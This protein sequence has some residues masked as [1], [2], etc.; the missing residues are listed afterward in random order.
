VETRRTNQIV[1]DLSGSV[2]SQVIGPDHLPLLVWQLLDQLD[3]RIELKVAERC[4]EA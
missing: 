3:D 4:S 2:S 1:I